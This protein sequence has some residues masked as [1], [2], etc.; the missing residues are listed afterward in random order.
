MVYRARLCFKTTERA[1][2]HSSIVQF[3]AGMHR[4]LGSTL[5]TKEKERKMSLY[6]E[7]LNVCAVDTVLS[8]TW[9]L[10]EECGS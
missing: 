1:R 5:G 8:V 9:K 3:R 7:E 6:E 10:L 2:E 4:A